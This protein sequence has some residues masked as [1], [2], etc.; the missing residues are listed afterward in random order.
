MISVSSAI[1][2][3]KLES[4]SYECFR[5]EFNTACFFSNLASLGKVTIAARI[6]SKFCARNR[7]EYSNMCFLNLESCRIPG[8]IEPWPKCHLKD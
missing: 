4:L 7:S 2:M 8:N 6:A 5:M 1:I 3:D